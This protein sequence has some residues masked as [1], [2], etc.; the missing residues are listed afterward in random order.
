MGMF[1]DEDAAVV[2]D[3]I[4]ASGLPQTAAEVDP[5]LLWN[6]EVLNQISVEHEAEVQRWGMN[7]IHA[8][9]HVYVDKSEIP[10]DIVSV[11]E[12]LVRSSLL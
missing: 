2:V 8:V 12:R 7:I 3:E 5:L 9:L 11:A 1:N 10:A 4:L 6:S